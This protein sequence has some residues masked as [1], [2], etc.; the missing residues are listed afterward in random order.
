MKPS[1]LLNFSIAGGFSPCCVNDANHFAR[2]MYVCLALIVSQHPNHYKK[3][4]VKI[5]SMNVRLT[6]TTLMS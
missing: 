3:P 6:M 2:A 4:T 5:Q 1:E